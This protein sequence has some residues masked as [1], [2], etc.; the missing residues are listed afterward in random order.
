[1]K[2]ETSSKQFSTAGSYIEFLFASVVMQI[3]FFATA[4][5]SGTSNSEFYSDNLE[6]IRF[7]LRIQLS[8]GWIMCIIA[9]LG[10]SI[11]PLIYDLHSFGK[12]AMRTYVGLNISGQF[13]IMLGVVSGMLMEDLLIFETLATVG[14]TLLCAS[15]VTLGP[16]AIS[17]F[18]IR[19]P[20]D[21]KLGPFTYTIG[22]LMPFLGAITLACWIL[23]ERV[24][25][26]LDLS[27]S[28]IFDFFI[29]LTVV[30]LIISHFNRRL[31]WNII[32]REN[33]G[34]VFSIFAFLLFTSV[35][36][37]P[38]YYRD[39]ISVR[40]FAAL[41]SA[42]YLFIFLMIN[43]M[44]IL[45]GVIDKKPFN[46]MLLAAVFWLPVVGFTSFIETLGYV[47]VSEG[48]LPYGR[49][50]LIFGVGFQSLWG[51][52]EYLHDDHK[53]LSIHRRKTNWLVL[54]SVN[55]GSLIMLQTFALSWMREEAIEGF[56]LP[57]FLCFA[58]S[59]ILILL[60]WIKNIFFSLDDWHKTPMFYDK[61]LAHP[62]E[63]SGFEPED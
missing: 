43:P 24:E 40:V 16:T 25:R 42:P 15:L 47:E 44:K 59:F 48:N 54:I 7:A 13:A 17:I 5:W 8:L 34:K 52:A 14:I 55:L 2:I 12:S 33:L 27:E 28:I 41:V 20:K 36:G 61:Y 10:F 38:M 63:G 21:N 32:K 49:L 58:I 4:M 19:N 53:K 35:I 56:P 22:A 50:I 51:F 9:G 37:E 30:A 11:L 62:V 6:H 1:M 23:R 29:V 60:H 31:D 45:K 57:M 26:I 18:K 39:E 3:L 46:K